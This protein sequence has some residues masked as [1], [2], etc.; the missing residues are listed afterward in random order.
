MEKDYKKDFPLLREHRDIIYFDNAATSQKPDC[1]IKAEEDFYTQHNA[2][3][4]RGSYPLSV[5]ATDIYENSRIK[6]QKFINAA[7]NR[8]IIFTRNSTESLNLIAYS[9]GLTN[10]NAGDK[11]LV[12]GM[13]HHSNM[14]P[15]QMVTK[16]KGA[17]LEYIEC[18]DDGSVDLERIKEQI[19][20]NT[21]IV[22]ITQVSNV[23]G[24]VNPIK[25]IAKLAHEKGAVIVVDGT[26]SIPHMR[27]DVQD[28]DAD[29]FVFSGHKIF[30]PMGIGVLY[31]K[32][33]LLDAMPPFL[34]GG[35]M[36]DSVRRDG[37]TYAEL[38]H[39]FE[40]GTVNARGAAGLAAALDYVDSI[41]YEEM[42]KREEEVIRHVM[43]GMKKIPHVHI[44]GSQDPKEHL[45]IVSFAVDG[46]HPHDVNEILIADGICIRAGHHCAQPLLNSLGYNSTARRSFM[47]YNTIREGEKFLK[48]LATVREKMGY[49]E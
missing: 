28:L 29:F 3:P 25:E 8:E 23:L 39:K 38:P 41:G 6:V 10:V 45:G 13:E 44:L 12:S 1:V 19:T 34:T 32:E 33:K 14:L 20:D 9:Y 47:F 26:R 42:Q 49:D 15:W 17:E 24:R 18:A 21:K 5:E 11:V 4:L 37:A 43:E 2:N 16:A 36:I 35:E 31:G 40:A 48:S 7:S 30:G 46:V 22:A 27:I